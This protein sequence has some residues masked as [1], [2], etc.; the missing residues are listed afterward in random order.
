MLANFTVLPIMLIWPGTPENRQRR[1]RIFISR[2]FRALL[3]AIAALR[4]GWVDVEGKQWFAQAGGKLVLA[5]HPMY[6]DVVALIAVLPTADCV[7]KKATLRNPFTRFF[8]KAAGYYSNE[9]SVEF[10][11]TCIHA[12]RNGHTLII[13]PQ[14]TRTLP[15]ET[16]HFKRGAAQ[17]AVR[18]NC[19]ILP[20][21]IHCSPP[22]L[23]KNTM[24]YQVPERPWRL[25]VKAY[26][27]YNP[28][29]SPQENALP[30]AIVA[31]R[32]TRQLEV[33]F[34]QELSGHE[35]PGAGTETAH[36]RFA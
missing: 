2:S 27:P 6:L 31:R 24:W 15:G 35:Y 26:P 11:D 33:F 34:N 12:L 32:L 30:N 19:W 20:V 4:L 21:M 5:T 10:L 29:A 8:A 25:L 23:V 3:S 36:N 28:A 9:D 17:V 7:V 18:S 1:I 16:L 14:G 22:A 13:F